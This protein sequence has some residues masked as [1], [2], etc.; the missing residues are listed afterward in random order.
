MQ[1]RKQKEKSLKGYSPIL[2]FIEVQSETKL[3][4]LYFKPALTYIYIGDTES[5][6]KRNKSK[7]QLMD[8]TFVRT[9]RKKQ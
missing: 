6:A 2:E 3:C 8:A 1:K 4:K 9:L 7:I 5:L